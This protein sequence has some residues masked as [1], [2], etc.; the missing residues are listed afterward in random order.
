MRLGLSPLRNVL[1][2]ANCC[3]AGADIRVEVISRSS[4]TLRRVDKLA[5]PPM[6][7]MTVH[8]TSCKADLV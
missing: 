3:G 6:P 5:H 7:L 4:W 8:Q 1:G 2:L